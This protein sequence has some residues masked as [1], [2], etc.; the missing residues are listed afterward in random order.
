MATFEAADAATSSSSN[1]LLRK[2]YLEACE[3]LGHAG[4]TWPAE[5]AVAATASLVAAAAV[6]ATTRL[7][8]Q[9]LLTL[10]GTL[11]RSN[12]RWTSGGSGCCA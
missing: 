11:E 2:H 10:V 7:F 4:V 12:W 6:E 5:A 9:Q 1:S 3:L 8:E